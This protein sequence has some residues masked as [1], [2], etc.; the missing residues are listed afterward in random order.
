ML[1]R[2]PIPL[3]QIKAGNN[4][5]SLLI[6]IRHIVIFCIDQKK[7]PKKYIIT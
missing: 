4:P 1:E 2:L 7:L 6:E 3:A 5:E